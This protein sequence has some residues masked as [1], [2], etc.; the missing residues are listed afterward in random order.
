MFPCPDLD[1]GDSELLHIYVDLLE[2]MTGLRDAP[3]ST[4]VRRALFDLPDEPDPNKKWYDQDYLERKGPVRKWMYTFSLLVTHKCTKLYMAKFNEDPTP[5]FRF[6][7]RHWFHRM[8]TI[9]LVSEA[10]PDERS[11]HPLC[12]A[13]GVATNPDLCDYCDKIVVKR[14]G[15]HSHFSKYCVDSGLAPPRLPVPPVPFFRVS[16]FFYIA[17]FHVDVLSKPLSF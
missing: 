14:I 10:G 2:T 15:L 13:R 17:A 12:F 6:T 11:L 4:L 8:A 7:F 1:F 3:S 16:W 5:Q 9:E